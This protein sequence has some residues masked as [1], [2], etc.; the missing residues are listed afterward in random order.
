MPDDQATL[1]QQANTPGQ[2]AGGQPGTTD[3]STDWKARFDGAIRKINELTATLKQKDD[4]LTTQS[5]EIEQLKSQLSVKDTEKTVAVGE[6]DKR[7]ETSLVENQTLQSELIELR[8]LKLKLEVANELGRPDLMKI[9]E[10][11]P[12]MTDKEALTTVMKDFAGFADDAVKAREKQLMAGVVQ[13][14]GGAGGGAGADTQP[15]TAESWLDKINNMPLGSKERA[16][17][18]DRYGDWLERQ[19]TQ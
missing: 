17:A 5:S 11:I 6:R 2:Q 10:R 4:Q 13:A 18:M 14:T 9:A 16:Q 1:D 3:P 19:H 7:L 8:G 12:A 15:S